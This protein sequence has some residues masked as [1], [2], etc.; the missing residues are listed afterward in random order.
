MKK[1]LF[2]IGS[3]QL[4]G[5]ETVLV[6]TVNGLCEKF[7]ITILLLEKR[8][9]LLKQLS[10]KVKIKYVCLG[11]E[12]CTN[13][14]Q[15][16]YNKLKMSLIYRFYGNK[17]FFVNWIHKKILDNEKF[18]VEVAFL[19]GII[20]DIIKLLP[21]HNSKKIA[22]IHAEVTSDDAK[23]YNEYKK[24]ING[25]DEIVGVSEDSIKIFE[26]TFPE[27]KGK[28]KLIHNYIDTN[29]IINK[30]LEESVDYE[31]NIINF[32][33]VGRLCYE[34]G[35]DRIIKIADKFEGKINFN[36][37]GD[38]IDK[39][40]L[41]KEINSKKIN[42]VKLLGLKTNPY[43]YIKD[44]DVFLLSSRSEA[45]P[46][47]VIEAMILNKKIVAT[48]VS[49][50]R[51]ILDGYDAKVIIPNDDDAIENGINKILQYN[52][53]NKIKNNN[54]INNNKNNLNMIAKILNN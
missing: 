29:K 33:S 16:K 47:V 41:I 5:A 49:G 14:F 31:K 52:N 42:N 28:I 6:D 13:N 19:T 54:F 8:G 43:P 24:I 30:S 46:T 22:W 20:A 12:Y 17:R 23:T 39:Q 32:I 44:A 7:D 26:R 11:D 4:G 34:K 38:G 37:I 36:I 1:I 27:T 40:K 53:K 2:A 48:D 51:E 45:Y 35:F 25:F 15:K 50:V 10:K 3:L 21:N 9:P 18:D